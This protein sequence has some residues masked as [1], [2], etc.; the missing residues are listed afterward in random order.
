MLAIQA[1]LSSLMAKQTAE[2][3]SF[4]IHVAQAALAA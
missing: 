1:G 3:G 4:D 2:R